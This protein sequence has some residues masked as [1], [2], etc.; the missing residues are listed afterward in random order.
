MEYLY[1]LQLQD[2]KYYVGKSSDPDA[3]YL[4]HKNG[5]GAAWTKKYKPVKLLD[6][7]LITSEYDETNLTKD[8]IKKYGIENVRGGPYT[9]LELDKTTKDVLEREFLSESNKCYNCGNS[10]HFIKQCPSKVQNKEE[11]IFK[12][13][14][15]NQ[16]LLDGNT[17][18]KSLKSLKTKKMNLKKDVKDLKMKKMNLK[19]NVKDLQKTKMDL[20]KDLMM[21]LLTEKNLKNNRKMMMNM[22]K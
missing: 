22:I 20:K 7:K 12:K 10:G 8:F 1:T 11:S 13:K 16:D 17:N 15:Q 14:I 4:Q 21:I 18:L 6:T 5:T 9:Q 2:G 3:R 19:K